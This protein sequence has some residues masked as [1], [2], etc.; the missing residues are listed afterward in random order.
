MRSISPE[1]SLTARP[2]VHNRDFA[3][4]NAAVN[5]DNARG[6]AMQ[7]AALARAVA[8]LDADANGALSMSEWLADKTGAPRGSPAA[9][10]SELQLH[11]QG[12]ARIGREMRVMWATFEPNRPPTPAVRVWNSTWSHVFSGL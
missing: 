11:L 9:E 7:A 8:R 1:S 5:S 6:G 10:A 3:L 2:R 12:T 4:V